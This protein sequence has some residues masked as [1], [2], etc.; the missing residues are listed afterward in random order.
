LGPRVGG[1]GG[2]IV[3]EKFGLHQHVIPLF[4]TY[5][6][7]DRWDVNVLLPIVDSSFNARVSVGFGGRQFSFST[8]NN[9]VGLGD[10]LVR[11]KYRLFGFEQFNVAVGS[12]IRFPTGNEND[13]RGKRDFILEPF[14]A[15]SQ[16]YDGSICTLRQDWK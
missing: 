14:L 11:T 8:K 12:A 13:L 15:A 1:S 3:I 4:A 9:G 5:G 7:T 2:S 10:V 16:E 6:I